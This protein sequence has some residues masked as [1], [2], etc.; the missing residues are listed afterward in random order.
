MLPESM[1]TELRTMIA[2]VQLAD[3]VCESRAIGGAVI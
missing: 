3:L 1:D 2:V